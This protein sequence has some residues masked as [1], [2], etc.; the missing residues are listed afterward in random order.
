MVF[1]VFDFGLS[2]SSLIPYPAIQR[3][4]RPGLFSV[5]ASVFS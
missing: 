4:G 3:F 1:L 5:A 2:Q